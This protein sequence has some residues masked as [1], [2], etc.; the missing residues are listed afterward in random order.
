MP[1][2]ATS[3]DA[4][5]ETVDPVSVLRRVLVVDDNA[6]AADM[7][8]ECLALLGATTRA[9]YTARAALDVVRSFAP[10]VVLLDLRMPDVS[11]AVLAGRLR[12]GCTASVVAVTGHRP[13]D[14]AAEIAAGTFDGWLTKPCSLE[15]LRR[16]LRTA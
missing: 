5:F 15:A 8:A 10:D 6:D 14:V 4:S 7:L 3:S 9:V 13:D 11:G 12:D 16:I 1:W 2:R